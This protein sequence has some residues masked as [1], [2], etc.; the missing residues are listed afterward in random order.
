MKCGLSKRCP[1]PSLLFYLIAGALFVLVNQFQENGWLEGI[2]IPCLNERIFAL[3]YADDTIFLLRGNDMISSK[4][5]SYLIFFFYDI[6]AQKNLQKSTIFG[7]SQ[8]VST[9]ARLVSKLGC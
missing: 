6:W 7:G 4:V 1:L 2:S 5:Q 9:I 8:D 3:Q